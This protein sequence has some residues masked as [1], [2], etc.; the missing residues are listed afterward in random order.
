MW[1][2]QQYAHWKDENKKAYY[3]LLRISI[4]LGI[5]IGIYLGALFIIIFV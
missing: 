5:G 3:S 2:F 1:Y 4:M